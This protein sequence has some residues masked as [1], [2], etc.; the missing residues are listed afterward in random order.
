MLQSLITYLKI[1]CYNLFFEFSNCFS[2]LRVDYSLQ[3]LNI[4]IICPENNIQDGLTSTFTPI[5]SINNE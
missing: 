3:S 5:L 2:I 4:C 1:Q